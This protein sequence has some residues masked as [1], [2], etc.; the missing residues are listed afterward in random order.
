VE[1]TGE[2]GPD[3]AVVRFERLQMVRSGVRASDSYGLLLGL[4]LVDYLLLSLM[5]TGR[6]FGLV[7]G[8]PISLT[9]LLA[10]HTSH[11]HRHGIRLAWMAVAVALVVGVINVAIRTDGTD[12]GLT[13]LLSLLLVV[14]P[15]VI[16]RRI[17]RHPEVTMETILGAICIYVVIGIF[18]GV[19]FYGI[20]KCLP[21]I[22]G[23]PVPASHQFLAQPGPHDS[24]D[25]LYLSFVTITTVGF[26][27]LTPLSRVARSVV[28]LEALMGQ[29]FLVTLVARLVAMYGGHRPT[30]EPATPVAGIEPGAVAD[31]GAAGV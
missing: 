1:S 3:S 10:L 18:F 28:V 31:D 9:L 11:A 2:A 22:Y 30:P 7:V 23:T 4:L 12:A 21:L 24:S 15:F 29:I 26:G 5:P 8:V 14:T 27:D 25:Y 20:S 19:L 17:L 6:W 16:V 13:I